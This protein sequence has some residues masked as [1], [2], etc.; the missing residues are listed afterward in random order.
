MNVEV[1]FVCCICWPLVVWMPLLPLPLPLPGP[2]STGQEDGDPVC[3]FEIEDEL[4]VGERGTAFALPLRLNFAI[5]R[6]SSSLPSPSTS[7]SSSSSLE[8]TTTF[9]ACPTMFA[10]SSARPLELTSVYRRSISRYF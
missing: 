4:L 5:N 10:R 9:L 3:E 7:S 1:D 6:A 8:R 2:E